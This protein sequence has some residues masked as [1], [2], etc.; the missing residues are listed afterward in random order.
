MP[1][2][3]LWGRLRHIS[4]IW[5]VICLRWLQQCIGSDT[6]IAVWIAVWI[7]RCSADVLMCCWAPV[8]R[9]SGSTSLISTS[10]S[11]RIR[12]S[13][14][15]SDLIWLYLQFHLFS[16]QLPNWRPIRRA[17]EWESIRYWIWYGIDRNQCWLTVRLGLGRPARPRWP[18]G[19]QSATRQ[20]GR[21]RH[22]QRM[23]PITQTGL[24]RYDNLHFFLSHSYQCCQCCSR[25]FLRF[26]DWFLRY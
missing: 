3:S 6:G 12:I 20:R 1:L 10:L 14:R 21:G 18:F 23:V 16:Q 24:S 13:F 26:N 25:I 4:C 2:S 8:E 9:M 11:T 7:E 5:L 15:S 17:E 22:D 19:H